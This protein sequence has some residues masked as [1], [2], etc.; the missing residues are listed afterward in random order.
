MQNP[1][2]KIKNPKY[3]IQNPKYNLGHKITFP[4]LG[5]LLESLSICFLDLFLFWGGWGGLEAPGG[6]NSSVPA[7]SWRGG[8]GSIS[9]RAVL[10]LPELWEGQGDGAHPSP[11]DS[12]SPD[13]VTHSSTRLFFNGS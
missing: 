3:K 7:L 13:S 8:T 1:K 12:S 10:A 6:A 9:P 4:M 5:T 2:Y 11:G